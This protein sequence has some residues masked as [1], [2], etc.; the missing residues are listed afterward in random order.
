[1]F[2]Y[3]VKLPPCRRTPRTGRLGRIGASRTHLPG[4]VNA[5]IWVMPQMGG[6]ADLLGPNSC[7]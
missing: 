2:G 1:M 3:Q 5:P 4:Q 6:Q 7:S